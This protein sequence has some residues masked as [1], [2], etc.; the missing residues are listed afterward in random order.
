MGGLVCER[1]MRDKKK[2]VEGIWE[3]GKRV[4]MGNK[5]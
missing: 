2:D 5:E 4:G 3:S 1:G